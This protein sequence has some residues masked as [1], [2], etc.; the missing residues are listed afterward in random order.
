MSKESIEIVK[1]YIKERMQEIQ[2]IAS[3]EVFFIR[4]EEAKQNMIDEEIQ[5]AMEMLDCL[6]EACKGDK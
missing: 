4:D 6:Y 5:R 3:Q 1:I 2:S